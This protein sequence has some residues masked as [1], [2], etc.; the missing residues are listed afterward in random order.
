MKKYLTLII[1][2]AL[3]KAALA[4]V[5]PA[6]NP[7][8]MDQWTNLG[9]IS[10]LAT[11]ASNRLYATS[12]HADQVTHKYGVQVHENGTWHTLGDLDNAITVY[13]A[14]ASD[15]YGNV[16]V[17]GLDSNG[18]AT[19]VFK[20]DGI[21]WNVLIGNNGYVPHGLT[22]AMST[23]AFGNLYI[24]G[25]YLDD[26]GSPAIRVNKW[27]GTSWN[28]LIGANCPVMILSI[29]PMCTDNVGN[30][31]VIT[32][33]GGNLHKC[34][35]KW[36][37]SEW[38]ELGAGAPT[39]YGDTGLFNRGNFRDMCSDD[40]GNIYV[41]GQIARNGDSTGTVAKWNGT[42]WSAVLND[43]GTHPDIEGLVVCHNNG[44][45][46]TIGKPGNNEYM[47]QFFSWNGHTWNLIYQ[48]ENQFIENYSAAIC[49]AS[50]SGAYAALNFPRFGVYYVSY[51][52]AA[53][54]I[55][56]HADEMAVDIFPNPAKDEL[57]IK[58]SAEAIGDQYTMYDLNG[59]QVLRG[60]IVTTI[61]RISISDLSAGTYLMKI[62]A[63]ST[64]Q[65]V[66][67]E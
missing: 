7:V 10:H 43:D 2:S 17:S 6:W 62:G 16:Y 32:T 65:K 22:N 51:Y 38:S 58:V 20:W 67:I 56:E 15:A 4:Q 28:R 11:D 8:D 37:G 44:I 19:R 59:R 35:M 30:V 50:G 27:D 61:T 36:N 33:T 9:P 24:A 64:P 39:E 12:T 48:R 3:Y 46:Y 14:L 42:S 18:V 23:D 57:Q 40:Q 52:D 63:T 29:S 13:T 26:T 47:Y 31:Y 53:T 45:L 49:K 34:V 60:K 25:T 54:G 66:I 21:T 41:V 55:S 5:I 1:I